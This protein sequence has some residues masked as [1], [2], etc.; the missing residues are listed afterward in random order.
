ME[1][2]GST[3]TLTL[4]GGQNYRAVLVDQTT[5]EEFEIIALSDQNGKVV[6]P[7]PDE[8]TTY[9]GW[10]SLD[11]YD[12][13]NAFAYADSVKATRPYATSSEIVSY[14][15]GKVTTTQ[16]I[17]YERIVRNW[18]NDILGYSFE[19][20]RKDIIG[21]GTGEEQLWTSE[22]VNHIYTVSYG[23]EVVWEAGDD[24]VTYPKG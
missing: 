21:L 2:F 12:E 24:P 10:F 20:V 23:D 3:I 9:D 14:M 1:I 19:F 4:N 18:I 11:V 16:A 7:L 13:D 22:R 15:Q 5:F 6:F 17:E 8:Y